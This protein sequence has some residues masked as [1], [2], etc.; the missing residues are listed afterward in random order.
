MTDEKIPAEII[1]KYIERRKK[2]LVLCKIALKEKNF[3]KISEIGHQIKGNASSFG[4]KELE[5]IAIELEDSA[6]H[7]NIS[8][9]IIALELFAKTVDRL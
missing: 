2:D 5:I 6:L 9:T 7:E 8:K 1:L 4:F 3:L